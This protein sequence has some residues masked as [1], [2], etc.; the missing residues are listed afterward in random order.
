MQA[1]R[2]FVDHKPPFVGVKRM[3]GDHPALA[4]GTTLYAARVAAPGRGIL[5]KS[6]Q[7]SR[8]IGGAVVKGR[9]AGM[10]IYTLTLEERATC[11]RD[12]AHWATCFGNKMNW[13][14][15]W[16][17][18]AALEAYIKNDIAALARQ[19]PRGFVV[20][21]HVLGD[22]Y[23][24]EY[25]R[26]WAGLIDAHPA[27]RVFGYTAR[28]PVGDP[29]GVHLDTLSRTRW[30][31]F[32]LRFSNR[33]M[34]DRSALTLFKPGGVPAAQG[35]ICPAQ[36]GRTD[37]CGTCALCWQATKNIFFQVH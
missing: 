34:A 2:R 9:W 37:C 18:G 15:R 14:T 5:F 27:L 21:L 22:F 33:W 35:V 17:H 4:A 10:P 12:C 29:I 26:L 11:P 36:T 23:S 30:D 1:K 25:V 32:A 8:K 24:V 13:S 20:R 6:G 19:H 28:D 31:R 7:H 3:A 16:R